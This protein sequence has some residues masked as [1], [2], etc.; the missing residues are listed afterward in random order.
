MIIFLFFF[1]K[2]SRFYLANLLTELNKSCIL[3]MLTELIALSQD[4]NKRFVYEFRSP[5]K[6]TRVNMCL[7]LYFLFI[8]FVPN[9]KA[10]F[11]LT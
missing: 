4:D 11:L 2:K 3:N 1:L 9:H 6:Y 8:P 7:P 5:Y 10:C